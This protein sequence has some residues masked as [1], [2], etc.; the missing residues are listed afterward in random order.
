MRLELEIWS[1]FLGDNY[2]ELARQYDMTVSGMRKLITRIHTK[3]AADTLH[4][5]FDPAR[6][7]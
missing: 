1:K 4:D 6:V 3:L 2:D 5:L 7:G